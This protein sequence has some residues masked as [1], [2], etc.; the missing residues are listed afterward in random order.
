[1]SGI[2]N[3]VDGYNNLLEKYRGKLNDF[4]NVG[5]LK[6][7]INTF[8]IINVVYEQDAKSKDLLLAT[9]GNKNFLITGTCLV[10][11]KFIKRRLRS[12]FNFV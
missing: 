9:V 2:F 3:L 6:V 4:E 8:F 11:L 1:M 7:N 12:Y 5:N 10:S